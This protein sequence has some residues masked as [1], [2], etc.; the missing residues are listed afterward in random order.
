M[1]QLVCKATMKNNARP[2]QDRRVAR[3]QFSCLNS[4]FQ[5]FPTCGCSMKR[6]YLCFTIRRTDHRV[7]QKCLKTVL[8]LV[9][10]LIM[11]F[12]HWIQIKKSSADRSPEPPVFVRIFSTPCVIIYHFASHRLHCSQQL[13][14]RRC[15]KSQGNS[16][17]TPKGRD[18]HRD[19]QP[20]YLHRS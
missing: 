5:N 11:F 8:L 9:S 13:Q 2:C 19:A 12:H 15:Q 16:M 18:H 6:N 3:L 14:Q 1:L 7:L 10:R 17:Q 20:Y 4:A